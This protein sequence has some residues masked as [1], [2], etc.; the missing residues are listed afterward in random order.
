MKESFSIKNMTKGKLPRLPFRRIKDEVLGPDYE[1]SIVLCG[2]KLSQELN[3][4]HR[5]KDKPTNVLSFPLSDTHGEIF[6]NI[7]LAKKQSG[8]FGLGPRTFIG[9]LVIHGMLHLKGYA[10]GSTMES[11]EARFVKK[12]FS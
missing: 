8:D 11:I 12:F 5:G 7:G 10:H 6:L 4:T 2:D 3:R 1:L 9:K